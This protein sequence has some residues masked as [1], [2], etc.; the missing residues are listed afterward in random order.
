MQFGGFGFGPPPNF[1]GRGLPGAGRG[2]SGPTRQQQVLAKGWAY[3]QLA[4]N[5]IQADN[6]AGLTAGIIGLTNKGQR[7]K[8]D[9]WGVL[10]AWAWGARRA[11]DYFET[12]PALDARHTAI[13]GHSRYGKAALVAMAYDPRLWAAYISSSGEAGAKLFRRNWGE[14]VENIADRNAYTGWRAIISGTQAHSPRPIFPW[15]RMSSSRCAHR[16]PCSSAAAPPRGDAWVDA[17]GMFMAAAAGPVYRLLGR[18]DLG[19][20]E[21]PPIEAALIDGDIAFRQH[22]SGHTNGRTGR[23]SSNGRPGTCS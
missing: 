6:G 23:S 15:I 20:T 16:T 12:N 17:K 9:D 10:R 3:A 13:E 8:S 7:R 11:V 1:A 18:K 19:T 4:P 21:F 5:S 14:T 2:P 22:S